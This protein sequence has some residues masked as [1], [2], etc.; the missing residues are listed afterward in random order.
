MILQHSLSEIQTSED[1]A[2]ILQSVQKVHG[3]VK[4]QMDKGI[5]SDRIVIGGF[6]QGGSIALIVCSRTLSSGP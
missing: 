6:S 4:E 2:G 3:I 1:E 5:A